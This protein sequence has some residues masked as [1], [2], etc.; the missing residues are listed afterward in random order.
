RI[1]VG[2]SVAV[3][4]LYLLMNVAFLT[5]LSPAEM[6]GSELVAAD[7][8]SSVFGTAAGLVV[9]VAS[10]MILISSANV[11]FLGLPRVAYGLA[12][13][14]LAPG[15]LARLDARST[16]RTAL[17]FISLWIGLLALSGTFELLI[18][19]MMTVAIAVDTMVLLGYFKLRR[20]RPDLVRPF[21]MPGHPWLAIVTVA[22]YV[23]ILV[24]LVATQPELSLGAGAMLA[25]LVVAGRI[26]SRRAAPTGT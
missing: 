23:A 21:R 1:L 20:S 9:T 16:P 4:I 5:A 7:A 11:N 13:N 2:G 15:S 25:A 3:M 24:I 18:R 19:F 6:A 22:L 8:I 26:T 14:G 17:T 10:L 12:Q